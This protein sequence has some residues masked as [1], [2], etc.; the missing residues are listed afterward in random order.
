MSDDRLA[1]GFTPAIHT[2]DHIAVD[3]SPNAVNTL[4]VLSRWKVFSWPV[5]S[6]SYL[7]HGKLLGADCLSGKVT[8]VNSK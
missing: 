2:S 4:C 8:E 1:A 5:V 3:R 6:A 7:V